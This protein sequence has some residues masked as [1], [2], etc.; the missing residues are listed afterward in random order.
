MKKPLLVFLLLV[1]IAVCCCVLSWRNRSYPGIHYYKARLTAR[2]ALAGDK[3]CDKYG[4]LLAKPDWKWNAIET[5]ATT[6]GSVGGRPSLT[7][8]EN[9]KI[10]LN[11]FETPDTRMLICPIDVTKKGFE[12]AVKAGPYDFDNPK[13]TEISKIRFASVDSSVIE[14]LKKDRGQMSLHDAI[15]GLY[16]HGRLTI[17]CAIKRPVAVA[18]AL[19]ESGGRKT[20]RV[21]T[22]EG[23]DC[24]QIQWRV[25][26]PTKAV[27]EL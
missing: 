23:N 18:Y 11:P 8:D 4:N 10:G 14:E 1:A 22:L 19:H 26:P 2:E 6:R 20:V 9:R 5:V 3:P 21:V 15:Q 25:P 24:W 16:S 13:I 12:K 17:H 7:Y 27:R